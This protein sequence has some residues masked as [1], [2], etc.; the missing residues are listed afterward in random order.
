MEQGKKIKLIDLMICLSDAMDFIDSSVVDHHK[1][2]AYI[3]H[4]MAAEMG[5][6]LAQQK[7]IVLAGAL[8]D[9]G[10]FSLAE[11]RNTLAFE[12][13]H[14]HRHAEN[15]YALLRLFSPL[16][17]VATMVRFH[18]VPW[19]HGTGREFKG[20]EVPLASHMLHLADRIAVLINRKKEILSQASR[21]CRIIQAGAG[22]LFHPE[23]VDIFMAMSAKEYFWLDLASPSI[24][25]I[26]SQRLRSA[27]VGIASKDML[28]FS[29][30]FSRIIDFKSPFTATH[31]SGV[32]A[33]AE[34]LAGKLGFSQHDCTAMRIAGYMHDLGKL[35]VPVEILDKP[36]GLNRKE[37]N[38][39][40]HHTFYT[41][42]I[43]Q[44]IAALQTINKW[45]AFH[46]ER[47]DGSGYPF[48]LKEKDL[49]LGSQVMAV[50]DVFT[51]LTEDRPYRRGM[52]RSDTL[53]VLDDMS[54]RSALNGQIVA[55]LGKHFNDLETVRMTAQTD[56][57]TKYQTVTA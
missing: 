9:I 41:Y 46:H 36:S 33:S 6:S 14:P 7:D 5:L 42:R 22:R 31:S 17:V 27:Q 25:T 4:S 10:A 8:H 30:L 43:L 52:K 54:V 47:L 32:A 35:A 37:F 15:G 44:P 34:F 13:Q 40:R 28:G 49:P 48:H 21:I 12:I 26:L 51:A 38:V 50:A 24:Q 45:A 20:Q 3:A 29:Q 19:D 23:L 16:S 53:R 56:A 18:H 55:V 11:R 1:R 2:V 39:V 57:R